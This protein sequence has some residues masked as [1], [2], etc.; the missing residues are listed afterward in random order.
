MLRP[1]LDPRGA[2]PDIKLQASRLHHTGHALACHLSVDVVLLVIDAH[3]TVGLHRAGKGLLVHSLEPRVRIDRLWHSRQYRELGAGH[4]RRMVAAGARLVGTLVIVMR[5][6]GRG[7]LGDLFAGAWEVDQQALVRERPMK[8]LDVG[9][10][11]GTMR[12]DHIGFH[13][14]APEKAHQR[15]GEIAPGRASDKARIVIKGEP[16][17]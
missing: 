16:S 6:K 7:D 1:L 2:V 4:T 14:N 8:A 15:R 13:P 11:V 17:R 12:R 5:Q 10:E 3:A 9:V